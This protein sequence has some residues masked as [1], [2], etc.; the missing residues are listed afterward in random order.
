MGFLSAGA[1]DST[2]LISKT[3]AR[4]AYQVIPEFDPGAAAHTLAEWLSTVPRSTASTP[5]VLLRD[6]FW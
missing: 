3:A 5:P 1:R 2:V 6:R 4:E